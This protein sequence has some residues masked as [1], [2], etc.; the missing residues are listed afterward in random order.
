MT[1]GR[2]AVIGGDEDIGGLVETLRLQRV[3]QFAQH[4][5]SIACARFAAG[6]IYAGRIFADAV[7]AIMLRHV[8]I[9]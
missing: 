8:G 2:K 4:G 3:Q 5:I 1:D 6:A 7:A 9:A